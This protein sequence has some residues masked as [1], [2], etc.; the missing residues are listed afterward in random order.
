V[1]KYPNTTGRLYTFAIRQRAALVS[2][3]RNKSDAHIMKPGRP[4]PYFQLLLIYIHDFGPIGRSLSHE[5]TFIVEDYDDIM[6]W[7][8][9]PERKPEREDPEDT[10]G[11][12]K[13]LTTE[14]IASRAYILLEMRP[15][16][17]LVDL[18]LLQEMANLNIATEAGQS[19]E[20]WYLVLM[21]PS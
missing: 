20:K 9:T 19:S 7:S 16:H 2:Q 13:F 5:E 4:V 14:H 15:G 3:A 18:A 1:F 10:E 6:S 8:G 21:S 12:M 11:G 17:F